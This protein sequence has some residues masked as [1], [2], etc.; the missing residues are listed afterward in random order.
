LGATKRGHKKEKVSGQGASL[1][2][3]PD[4]K[5]E[6]TGVGRGKKRRRG[7]G[8]R[9]VKGAERGRGSKPALDLDR[10]RESDPGPHWE[11]L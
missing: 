6:V 4:G 1:G 11:L 8:S 5:R 10:L 9:Q 2:T 3:A 7:K